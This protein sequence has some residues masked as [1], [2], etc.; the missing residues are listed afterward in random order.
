MSS[1]LSFCS[2]RK[3]E[4]IT[5]KPF[6]F[7]V[8]IENVLWTLQ[9]AQKLKLP[10]GSEGGEGRRAAG[11]YSSVRT[12]MYTAYRRPLFN[13]CFIQEKFHFREKPWGAGREG[14]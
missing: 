8:Q 1:F 7:P 6:N 9:S 5:F 10:E 3:E 2:T 14:A 11:K 4:K 12:A 13:L